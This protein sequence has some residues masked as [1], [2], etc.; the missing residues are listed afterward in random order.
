[1][2][3]AAVLFLKHIPES[4]ELAYISMARTLINGPAMVDDAGNRA[5]YNAGYPLLVVAPVFALFGEI[6]S[7]V[8]TANAILGAVTIVLCYFV[9]AE[10]GAG[11][12]GRRIAAL[13]WAVYLPA[14]V[15]C[16]YVL[17][18]NLLT[19]LMLGTIW[20]LL[21]LMQKPSWTIALAAGL[22]FGLISLTGNAGLALAGAAALTLVFL[23]VNTRKRIV[24]SMIVMIVAFITVAPWLIRNAV[25]LGS[26]VLNTNGG[27]NLYLGNNPAA[28]GW[29]VSIADTPRGGSWAELRRSGE[30]RA[31]NVLKQEALAWIAEH[32]AEFGMLAIKKVLYFWTPPFHSGK[33]PAGTVESSV[34]LLWAIEFLVL[35]LCA[36]ATVFLS[37]LRER[38]CALL[39]TAVGCYTAVHALFYVI[40]RYREPI[41]PLVCILAALAVE[42]Y[43]AAASS[44]RVDRG[45]S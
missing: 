29:F 15:Y 18:E 22:L 1:M 30:V 21:R 16:V 25:V 34:R 42:R 27:F 24:L 4:D 5:M 40:F 32:P 37:T 36:L 20:C 41:M 7:P 8:L 11:R 43:F 10:A 2:R 39:W 17:K 23:P 14:S 3:V 6:V 38:R 33:Q 9:A 31:S 13:S 12:W 45:S 19:P 44:G 26:P 28:T 35:A